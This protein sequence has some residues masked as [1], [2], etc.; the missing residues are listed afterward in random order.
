MRDDTL[1]QAMLGAPERVMRDRIE[2]C[3]A[4]LAAMRREQAHALDAM[5]AA[6][7]RAARLE[8]AL[9]RLAKLLPM[10]ERAAIMEVI[11]AR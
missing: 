2:E 11:D 8:R 4:G 6:E 3:Q 10:R 1:T 5:A 7:A 9:V